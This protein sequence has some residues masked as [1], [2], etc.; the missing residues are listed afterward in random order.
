[1]STLKFVGIGVMVAVRVVDA[2]RGPTLAEMTVCPPPTLTAK[3]VESIVA[4][5]EEDEV[6]SALEETSLVTPLA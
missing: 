2:V 4:T 6:Q 3:P 1:M 5:A